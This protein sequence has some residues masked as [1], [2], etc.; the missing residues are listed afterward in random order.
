MNVGDERKEIVK[1]ILGKVTGDKH[2]GEVP[3]LFIGRGR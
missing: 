2:G 1:S 3:Q